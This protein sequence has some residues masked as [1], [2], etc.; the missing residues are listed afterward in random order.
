MTT[1]T[2]SVACC[3]IAVQVGDVS[4][5]RRR[6]LRA[7]SQAANAGAQVVVL[8]ELTNTGYM[9]RDSEELRALS[10]PLDG[11]TVSEWMQ[12]AR[13]RNLVIVGGFAEREPDAPTS[14]STPH[15]VYNSA[16]VIDATGL[17]AVYRKAHLWDHEK[18][19]G[20]TPGDELPLVVDTAVGRI[21]V[22]ICY[23]LEFP[24]W[25]RT[26]A[27][28]RAELLCAPVNWPLYP[29]PEGERPG[30][31][32][33]V[34][35]DA[36]VNRMFIAAADRSGTERGQD[37]LGGSTIV[38]PDGYPLAMA[39]LG[40]AGTIMTDID[41]AEARNKSIS[42]NNDVHAD[43]RPELYSG[44]STPTSPNR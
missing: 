40:R 38:D 16:V 39:A 42:S 19:V 9:F 21:G 4:G 17:L 3:Q 12:A 15:R 13:D 25:I 18:V 10:E 43:R 26:V 1:S 37:W 36:S 5:N 6:V 20:F 14:D 22:V 11:P 31:I 44:N 35:A 27:L 7:V 23:D 41:L 24:E 34:Q 8:P 33:K 29:R 28:A 32:V 2:V 30:E